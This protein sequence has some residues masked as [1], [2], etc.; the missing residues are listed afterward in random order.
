VG[1][2]LLLFDTA[3]GEEMELLVGTDGAGVYKKPVRGRGEP[4]DNS[5]NYSR[6]WVPL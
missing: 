5:S 2:I 6:E 4:A 3:V 1:N